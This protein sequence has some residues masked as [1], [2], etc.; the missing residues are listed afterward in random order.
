[1]LTYEEAN[2][3]SLEEVNVM[4]AVK[5]PTW[6]GERKSR[7]AYFV[8]TL[9]ERYELPSEVKQRLA[10]TIDDDQEYDYEETEEIAKRLSKQYRDE[11]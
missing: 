4:E 11:K 10:K 3:M 5:E 2:E 1:M 6:E 8:N 7:E 9:S